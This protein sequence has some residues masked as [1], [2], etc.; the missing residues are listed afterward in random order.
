VD[1]L[2][3]TAGPDLDD[4]GYEWRRELLL[5]DGI[6]T[7]SSATRGAGDGRNGA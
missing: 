2:Y 7:N 4:I 3:D 1:D 5:E 6:C